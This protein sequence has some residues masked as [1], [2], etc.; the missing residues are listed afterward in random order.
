MAYKLRLGVLFYYV[1]VDPIYRGLYV[2][3]F[4]VTLLKYLGKGFWDYLA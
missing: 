2:Q 3:G 1:Q 4:D